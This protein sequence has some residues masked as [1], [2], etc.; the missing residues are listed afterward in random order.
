MSLR[1]IIHIPRR[2]VKL[3]LYTLLAI[4]IL[5][6]ALTRTQVG[7]EGLRQQFDQQFNHTFTGQLKIG[8]LNGNFVNTLFAYDIALFD[9]AGTQVATIDAAIL[10]PTWLELFTGTFSMNRVTLTRPNLNLILQEDSTWNITKLFERRSGKSRLKAWQFASSDIRISDGTIQTHNSGPLPD[11]VQRGALIDFTNLAVNSIHGQLQVRWNTNLKRID[12]DH[13]SF[14]LNE[15]RF[16]LEN[17]KGQL[18]WEGDRVELNE[19]Q[20]K[21]EATEINLAGWINHLDQFKTNPGELGLNLEML[22]SRIDHDALRNI[23][24]RL[25]FADTLDVATRIAGSVNDL[26]LEWLQAGRGDLLIASTGTIVG[27]PDSA[28]FNLS[29][30]NSTIARADLQRLLPN[31]NLQHL[32]NSVNPFFST[33]DLRGRINLAQDIRTE[34]FYGKVN[35]VLESQAGSLLG[36]VEIEKVARDSIIQYQARLTADSL[37]LDQLIPTTQLPTNL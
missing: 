27:L 22:N 25:P 37:N 36:D 10:K 14:Q 15:D 1:L 20:L 35:F 21:S 33:L 2:T 7:R 30:A 4:A 32:P 3:L 23:F 16:P 9:T 26:Q 24:P 18:V 12:I 31:A 28:Q 11:A 34:P 17:L 6:I 13:F 19:V 5:F 29:L 8:R